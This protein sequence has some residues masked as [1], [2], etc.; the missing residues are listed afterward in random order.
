MKMT[1]KDSYKPRRVKVKKQEQDHE[2]MALG[3][4]E[5]QKAEVT[6]E[7]GKFFGKRWF[8]FNGK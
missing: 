7:R 2:A 6:A 8:P 3:H 4:K 1:K 5:V